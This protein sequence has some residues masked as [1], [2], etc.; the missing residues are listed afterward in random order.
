MAKQ[1]KTETQDEYRN[2][3]MDIICDEIANSDKGLWALCDSREDLPN[4]R[5]ITTWITQSEEIRQKYARAKESQADFMAAQIIELADQCRIGKK[6]VSKP[7]G[8]EITEGDMVE[9]SR[10]QI[11]ARKWLAGKLAPKKY[12]ERITH[13]GDEE[14]PIKTE[15]TI[16]RPPITREDWLKLHGLGDTN[17]HI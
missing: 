6:K 5:T 7:S 17:E 12:G 14:N 15:A 9:R 10:L 1:P 8:D 4:P 11:D 16:L 3:V 2:R 13:S